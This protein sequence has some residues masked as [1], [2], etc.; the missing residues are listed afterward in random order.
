MSMNL[1]RANDNLKKNIKID[2]D[3]GGGNL[4]K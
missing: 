3:C 2:I 4:M 1:N